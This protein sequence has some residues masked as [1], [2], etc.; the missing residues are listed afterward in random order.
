[1]EIEKLLDKNGNPSR[2]KKKAN[3]DLLKLI[4]EQYPSDD[5]NTSIYMALHKVPAPKCNFCSKPLFIRN[6]KLG[7]VSKWCSNQCRNSDPEYRARLKESLK[8]VNKEQAQRKREQTN[9]RKYGFAYHSQRDEVKNK[10]REAYKNKK[11]KILEKARQTWLENL[12]STTPQNLHLTAE[13]LDVLQS[14]E[15]LGKLYSSGIS[16]DRIAEQLNCS[17]TTVLNYLHRHGIRLRERSSGL[18]LELSEHLDALG[19]E[20]QTNV[21]ILEGKEIDFLLGDVGIEIHGIFWH[22]SSPYCNKTVFRDPN[23]HLNKYALAKKQNIKLLQ[24]FEDEWVY[25]RNACLNIIRSSAGLNDTIY[26]RKTTVK[27]ISSTEAKMFCD[28]YHLAGGVFSKFNVGLFYNEELVL[29]MTFSKPRFETNK[30]SWEIIRLCSKT[31]ISVV[32]GASKAFK[33][34]LK[35]CNPS[36]VISYSDNRVG[37]GNVYKILGFELERELK[38]GYFWVVNGKRENRMKYQKHK[39]KSSKNYSDSLSEKEIMFL[40][41]H[42]IIYDAG[43]KKWVYTADS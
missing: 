12:G 31:G 15:K 11:E 30:D 9:L 22:S 20:Y 7:F 33:F 23:Y 2:L 25:K 35:K 13:C 36:K 38:P 27:E 42:R 32:G 39:L 4:R 8:T 43:H 3:P 6:F 14:K 10:I 18:E 21:R 34:F 37:S 28:A 40:D 1:M 41:G 26:A 19:I 24:F 29:V 17:P 16:S 5:E